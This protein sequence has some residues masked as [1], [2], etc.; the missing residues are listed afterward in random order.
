M[1]CHNISLPRMGSQKFRSDVQWILISYRC[2]VE[3]TFGLMSTNKHVILIFRQCTIP[4]ILQKKYVITKYEGIV[5]RYPSHLFSFSWFTI[6][7]STELIRKP[8]KIAQSLN[9]AFVAI[10]VQKPFHTGYSPKQY[11]KVIYTFRVVYRWHEYLLFCS[12]FWQV[13]VHLVYSVTQCKWDGDY[14]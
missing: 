12:T 5:F 1:A 14:H 11:L 13:H 3:N 2:A 6:P 9:Y 4:I 8:I 10:N 7:I